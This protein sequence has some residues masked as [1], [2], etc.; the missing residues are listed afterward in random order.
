MTTKRLSNEF[1]KEL[2]DKL[3]AKEPITPL[4]HQ[5][6]PFGTVEAMLDDILQM[7]GLLLGLVAIAIKGK[8]FGE[9]VR[10]EMFQK[11]V[12]RTIDYLALNDPNE[13]TACMYCWEKESVGK[14]DGKFICQGCA[15]KHGMDA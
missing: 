15:D 8:D 6:G 1:C 14:K 7:R 13:P 10:K 2:H 3:E 4:L 9:E 5:G 11:L 12:E